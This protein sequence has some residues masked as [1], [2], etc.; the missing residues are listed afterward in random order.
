MNALY[1]NIGSFFSFVVLSLFGQ[2]KQ[3]TTNNI[4]ELWERGIACFLNEDDRGSII[5]FEKLLLFIDKKNSKYN[6]SCFYIAHSYR[7]IL[8]TQGLSNAETNRMFECYDLYLD[9]QPTLMG[10]TK[11][12]EVKDF[13]E[14]KKKAM[15][16]GEFK[17]WRELSD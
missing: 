1:L 14:R 13:I 11:N 8:K 12:Q 3:I 15:P 4:E 2:Q 7:V 6:P 16:V 5:Y 17:K 9:S 10:Q